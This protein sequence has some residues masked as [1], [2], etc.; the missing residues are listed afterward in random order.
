MY[1]RNDY[2]GLGFLILLSTIAFNNFV[3]SKII[4]LAWSSKI[5]VPFPF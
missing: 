2:F 5:F 1:F 4:L 3:A